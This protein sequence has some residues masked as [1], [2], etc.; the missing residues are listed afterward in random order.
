L[1][2]NL[3]NELDLN[4]QSPPHISRIFKILLPPSPPSSLHSLLFFHTI[5]LNSVFSRPKLSS[6]LLPLITPSIP[7]GKYISSFPPFLPHLQ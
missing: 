6:H 4:I 2:G 5:I 7:F 3:C 1:H